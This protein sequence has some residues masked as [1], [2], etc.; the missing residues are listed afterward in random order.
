[1]FLERSYVQIYCVSFLSSFINWWLLN[2]ELLTSTLI[3]CQPY[4]LSCLRNRNHSKRILAQYE[5][6]LW[7]K[8][9][10][11]IINVRWYVFIFFC[12]PLV[13][14]LSCL[15]LSAFASGQI[16]WANKW[17]RQWILE[18]V[19]NKTEWYSSEREWQK[20]PAKQN[21]G[22]TMIKMK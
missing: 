4:I 19:C 12:K 7:F 13:N 11:I 2:A 18:W 6:L 9:N 22:T 20:W 10:P 16:K 1:M 15:F 17:S 14:I 3:C 21:S 8:N 5:I